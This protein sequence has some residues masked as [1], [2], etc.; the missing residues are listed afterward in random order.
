MATTQTTYSER[1]SEG[2]A[3]QIATMT[4]CVIDSYEVQGSAGIPFGRAVQLGNQDDRIQLG[5]GG[6]RLGEKITE[7]NGNAGQNATTIN[8][9]SSDGI[10]EHDYIW[11]GEERI[12]VD[13]ISTNALTVSRGQS[14]TTNR[15]ISND[16][17]VYRDLPGPFQADKFLGV[18]LR[19]KSINGK[20]GATDVD[21][22]EEGDIA[23]VMTQGD[24]YVTVQSA[25]SYGDTVTVDSVTGE[26]SSAIASL[27]GNEHL[28]VP[29]RW[30]STAATGKIA[31]LRLY[32]EIS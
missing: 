16:A 1:I 7:V 5:V 17:S 18:V 31:R 30:M 19:D 10:S 15:A 6:P 8:V 21:E 27:A 22:Y 24:V 13:S 2:I 23:A 25:V 32:G 11:I 14:S 12:H 26:L 3:G 9:D 28:A 20:S 4:P 29:G